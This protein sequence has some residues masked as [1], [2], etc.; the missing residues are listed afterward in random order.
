VSTLA[1]IN[2]QAS[3]VDS[4]G[5]RA[6]F[7]TAAASVSALLR[8]PAVA[9]AWTGPSALAEFSVGG[10]AAHLAAQVTMVPGRLAAAEPEGEPVTLLEHYGRVSWIGSGLDSEVNVAIRAVGEKA[11]APGAL[12]VADA[13]DTATRELAELLPR[14][15]VDRCVSPPAGPW[16]LR[17]DDFLTTRMMEIAVH[18]DDVACSVGLDTPELPAAALQPVLG[19]LASLAARRHGAPAVLRALARSERAP[20]SVSA[21]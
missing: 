10:L 17:L 16:A 19:L 21:F 13:I 20:A 14:E 18:S 11:A 3:D 2:T 5:V 7:L 12:E 6:A 15:T 1:G 4:Q 9:A 8:D